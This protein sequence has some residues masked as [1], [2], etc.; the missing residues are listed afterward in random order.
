MKAQLTEATEVVAAFDI[1]GFTNRPAAVSS[2][3]LIDVL[4][5]YLNIVYRLVDASGGT[6]LYLNGDAVA[7]FWPAPGTPAT[8]ESIGRAIVEIIA[9]TSALMLPGNLQ[10]VPAIGVVSGSTI[11]T[12]LE[13]AGRTLPVSVGSAMNLAMR[14]SSLCKQMKKKILFPASL[15]VVW[16]AEVSTESV[17]TVSVKGSGEPLHLMS[18]LG[19]KI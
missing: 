8:R 16:P 19:P 4:E 18:L 10:C 7:G 1:A 14:L 5:R 13:V 17:I 2:N 12:S 9:S 3:E 6:P 15:N 11:H